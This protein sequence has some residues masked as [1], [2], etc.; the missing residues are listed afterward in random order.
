MN[1]FEETNHSFILRIWMESSEASSK[2]T[3]WRGHI[4]HVST[5]EERYFERF[6]EANKFVMSKIDVANAPKT[7]SGKVLH[8]L[9]SLFS[10]D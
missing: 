2:K 10:P 3:K 4:V 8:K 9:R 5:G 1:I 6:E 7:L